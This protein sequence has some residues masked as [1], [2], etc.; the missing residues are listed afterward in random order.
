MN[1]A[2]IRESQWKDTPNSVE[3]K[4]KALIADTKIKTGM[5]LVFVKLEKRIPKDNFAYRIP[6][7]T[8]DQKTA[9]VIARSVK[10]GI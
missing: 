3:I 1:T 9:S 2:I 4:G 5:I 6:I 8:K 10:P 7:A